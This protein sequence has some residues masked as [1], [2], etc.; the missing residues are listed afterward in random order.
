M[1]QVNWLREGLASLVVFLVALPLCMGIAIASGVPPA[2][3]LVAGIIGGLVVGN[4]AGSP[5][6]VSGPAAGLV[7]IV[8][9]LVQSHGLGA[10]SAAILVSGVLQ[11][12]AGRLRLG[13]WFRAIAP[14]VIYGMLAGIG[15]LIAASQ[16]HVMVDDTP[17]ANGLLNIVTIPW[18]VQKGLTPI[19]GTPH[20][21]AAA[22]GVT[23]LLVLVLWNWI[24]ERLPG[25]LSAI[26]APL[27]AVG[28]AT[29]L[30]AS[31]SL[32]IAYI[33]V[34]T[35]VSELIR[36]P[37]LSDLAT[38]LEPAVLGTAF[39]LA[40]VAS[41]ESLLCAAAVDKLHDG[42]RSD[43]DRELTAQGVGNTLAGVLGALPIT[44]VIVRSTANVQA[45]ATTRYSAVLHGIWLLL[46]V[47]A[48]PWL[49]GL[50]PVASLAAVLVY[51]GYKLVNPKIIRDLAERGRA[52]LGIYIATVV[53]IV[54][55]SLLEGLLV[56]LALSVLKMA[57]TFS[58]LEVSVTKRD[59]PP[60]GEAER[61]IY[62]VQL[63]GAAT[64]VRLPLLMKHL[65]SIPAEAEVHVHFGSLN[66]IDHACLEAIADWERQREPRGG[67]VV[68]EWSDLES[69]YEQVKPSQSAA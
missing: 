51:I 48:L 24:R 64:F 13:Q 46:T 23:T 12:V 37:S 38:L 21:I 39:A 67:T 44:G 8:Y 40:V 57:W 4:L 11:I 54:A 3:G 60:E 49:L 47:A 50:V 42:P 62:D 10:L 1:G 53:A 63:S 7:V 29:G 15:I 19:E 2:M 33:D 28:V 27:V 59:A 14:A 25:V 30:S 22:I 41:A 34:P 20:H 65:E 52:E 18:A 31:M 6:Q 35:E 61:D 69:R 16:F 68:M 43:L 9:D 17:K 26:P 32:P 45:G 55:T 56:G 66:H 58:H 36:V 5:L